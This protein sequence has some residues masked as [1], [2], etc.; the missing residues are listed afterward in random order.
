MID[1]HNYNWCLQK[2]TGI[3]NTCTCTCAHYKYFFLYEYDQDL[4]I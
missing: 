1:V 4:S 3:H 2:T